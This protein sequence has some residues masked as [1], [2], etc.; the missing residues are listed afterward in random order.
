MPEIRIANSSHAALIAELSRK[1]FYDS[2][3][4]LNTPEDMQLFMDKQ[5][6]YE[7]L[8]DEVGREG[9]Y[10]FIAWEEDTPVGYTK[11]KEHPEGN[12]ACV[13][14][15]PAIE[16]S[17]FYAET[18]SIGKGIGRLMMEYAISFANQLGKQY[19]WLGVWGKNERAINFYRKFGFEKV[20]SHAFLLGNDLQTDWIMARKLT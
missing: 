16:I 18:G 3:A 8:L 19:I 14:V 2:F 4:S 12:P 9:N 6:T 1:T 7:G 5:F 10:F 20:G 17:R 15:G 13:P 11:M